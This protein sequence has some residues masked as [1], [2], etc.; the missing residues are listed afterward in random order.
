MISG[1]GLEGNRGCDNCCYTCT[2]GSVSA[3]PD[4]SARSSPTARRPARLT[5][6][7]RESAGRRSALPTSLGKY[8]IDALLGRGGMGEGLQGLRPVAR[9]RGRAEDH[10]PRDPGRSL[11]DASGA[12]S[13]GGPASASADRPSPC[14]TSGRSREPLSW[15]WNTSREKPRHRDPGG[16]AHVPS[17]GG[18]PAR[19]PGW[20]R[21]RAPERSHPPGHQ[22]RQHPGPARRVDQDPRLRRGPARHRGVAEP[23]RLRR[24]DGTSTC[25]RAAPRRAGRRAGRRLFG[26]G[27]RLRAAVRAGGPSTVRA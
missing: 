25:A 6:A 12:R 8:R 1:I 11:L 22:A 13:S 9:S 10:T 18:G 20:P 2:D 21:L 23:H 19:A 26:G 7:S 4:A 3:E 27:R 5:M 15:R 24:G 16:T 17:Q 14:T